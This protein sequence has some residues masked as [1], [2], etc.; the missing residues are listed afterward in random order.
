MG[1]VPHFCKYILINLTLV[2]YKKMQGGVLG[3][4]MQQ[5]QFLQERTVANLSKILLCYEPYKMYL[6]N[7][8][9]LQFIWSL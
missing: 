4:K 9:N 6:E 3:Q 5:S 2:F 7:V 1:S 8:P